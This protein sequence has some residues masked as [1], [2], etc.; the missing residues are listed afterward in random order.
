MPNVPAK[1]LLFSVR[2]LSTMG[3]AIILPVLPEMAASFSLSVAGI[4]FA[5]VSF[6]LAEAAMTPVA[7]I[8]SDRYGRKTVLL[9]ALLVFAAGG[10][11]ALFARTWEELI[12]CRML[13]GLGAGPLGVLYTIL[14]ADMYD[15]QHLPRIM[16][17]LTAVGSMGSIVFPLAGGFVGEWSWRM[18]FWGLTL[19]V[20]VALLALFVPLH[21]PTGARP[22]RTYIREAAGVIMHERTIGFFLLIFLSYCIIY[23]PMNACFPL[24]AKTKFHVSSSTI[25]T[26]IT[27]MAMGSWLGATSLPLLH[28]RWGY[29]FRA[30]MFWGVA[31]YVLSLAAIPLIPLLWLCMPPLFLNGLAQGLTLPIIND[32]VAMLAPSQDRAAILAASETFVRCS[33]SLSP[34]IFTLAWTAWGLEGPYAMGAVAA[35]VMGVTVMSLFRIS[36]K[37]AM[38]HS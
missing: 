14:A 28:R 36:A 29:P 24:L 27:A 12:F 6:T 16:S 30:I 19:A 26:V 9:P 1:I 38:P 37:D 35:L 25:G 20:P 22:F 2:L 21:R 11:L 8:L 17:K 13:Q 31:A 7:G 34:V 4:G 23:G 15:E 5:L 33:Q 18:P 32:N 3:I 10:A